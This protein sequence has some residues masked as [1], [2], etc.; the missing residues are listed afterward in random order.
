MSRS[1]RLQQEWHVLMILVVLVTTL[2]LCHSLVRLCTD[3]AKSEATRDRSGAISRVPSIAGPGGYANT[4]API[5]VN[6]QSPEEI[7]GLK[8]PPP[9][10][11]L[12]RCSYVCPFLPVL[13]DPNMHC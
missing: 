7:P 10:Y 9:V 11:G 4:R 6:T 3:L 12:W 5:R 8:E 13:L 2:F 1:I